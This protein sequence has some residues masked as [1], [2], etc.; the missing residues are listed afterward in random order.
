[1]LGDFA[2]LDADMMALA[3]EARAAGESAVLAA[4]L[5]GQAF[6]LRYYAD[7]A[8]S[9]ARAQEAVTAALQT[10]DDMLSANTW[11]A[12][13][14]LQV[15]VGDLEGAEASLAA[16]SATRP[17]ASDAHAIRV[18]VLHGYLRLRQ[19]DHQQTLHDSTQAM[20]LARANRWSRWEVLGLNL[21]GMADP[22]LA[23]RG[24]LLEQMLET[25][26]R[27]DNRPDQCVALV[28]LG[29]WYL[30]FG[31]Y[32]RGIDL[33]GQATAMGLDM[34]MHKVYALQILCDAHCALN[35]AEAALGYSGEGIALARKLDNRMLEYQFWQ[36]QAAAHLFMGRAQ[37]A[38]ADLKAA[39]AVLPAEIPFYNVQRMALTALA[40]RVVGDPGAARLLAAE[41]IDQMRQETP[42]HPEWPAELFYWY[43]YC[44][45]APDQVAAGPAPDVLPEDLWQV[46]DAGMQALLAPVAALSDAGLRRSY[47]HRVW[48]H[49]LLI[50]E[51]L[52]WAPARAGAEAIA[53][54]AEQVQRPG[55]LDD[56]FRRLL[57]VG[58]R[59]NRQHDPGRLAAQIV[60]EAAELTG[61]ERIALVLLDANGQRVAAKVNLPVPPPPLVRNPGPSAPTVDTF[62]AEIDPWLARAARRQEPFVHQQDG[63]A[64]VEQ[65]SILVT[66]LID[67]GRLLGLIYCDLPACFGRFD[68]KD[69]ELLGVL[70]N[71]SAVALEN[72]AA[73]SQL[74]SA[75]RELQHANRLKDEFM[76]AISHELRTPLMGVLSMAEVLESQVD[77]VLSEGQARN[78]AAI[79][80]NGGRL[81]ALINGILRYTRLLDNSLQLE[82]EE[83]ALEYLATI[84]V[85]AT[86]A[87]AAAKEQTIHLR[88]TPPDLTINTNAQGITQVLK[89]LLDNASKFTPTGGRVG[90]TI[91]ADDAAGC[92]RMEVR[93]TGPGIPAAQHEAIFH[94]F[95]QLDGGLARRHEGIGLG[96]AYARRMVERLGGVLSVES[97]PG[98]GSRFTVT[99]PINEPHA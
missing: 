4:V 10:Q 62:L 40:S 88:I 96:L 7:S 54:F 15:D 73:N 81:L 80:Q 94:P 43:C 22:D 34:Q 42:G 9:L 1:M 21:L 6:N 45:L 92:V 18:L 57:A 33:V 63:D 95:V 89:Q 16:L 41:T 28:N 46:L 37:A 52:K 14:V 19:G 12:Q 29:A 82:H 55:R 77:G 23:R 98:Q 60:D 48:P 2:A 65:R 61:A 91:E 58:I 8:R 93:D 74:A 66:P 36:L 17:A 3:D 84:V 50:Y 71:Q 27:L 72:A 32:Q 20:L 47:L 86:R 85:S 25:C 49:R 87:A 76:A 35:D 64:L 90:L 13:G 11:F 30:Q 83:C 67:R 51:W 38:L 44:A 75:L 53:A 39:C 24:L 79:H 99:L 5:A 56:I 70:A 78:V 97:E 59:L 26:I 68:A 31:M 69:M